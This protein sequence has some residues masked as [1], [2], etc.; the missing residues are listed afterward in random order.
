MYQP[1]A[2]WEAMA[3]LD[4]ATELI[5]EYFDILIKDCHTDNFRKVLVYTALV[6][7]A[8]FTDKP[9]PWCG[10]RLLQDGIQHISERVIR[11]VAYINEYT[12]NQ[13]DTIANVY[14]LSFIESIL[15]NVKGNENILPYFQNISQLVLTTSQKHESYICTI[16]GSM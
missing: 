12:T 2:Y 11:E 5:L 9:K 14:A 10:Y 8:V 1:L 13:V 15:I 3:M 7:R 4:N 6:D 16:T